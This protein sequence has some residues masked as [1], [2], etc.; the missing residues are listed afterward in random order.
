MTSTLSTLESAFGHQFRNKDLFRQA[1][2][3]PS[4]DLGILD[5]QRLEFLGDAVL[6]LI[7][8]EALY[9]GYPNQP[10][11]RLDQMRASIINGTS[12]AEKAREI[13][14]PNYLEISAA[15]RQ[16]HS[17]PSDGMLEDAFE[18]V[19]GALYLDGG[20]AAAAKSIKR[21]FQRELA[22]A[23]ERQGGSTNPKN[24]LQE[25]VQL[26]YNG[27]KPEYKVLRTAGPAH[28]RSFIV[29]VYIADRPIAC[30][31]GGSK[32]TAETEA[33]EKALLVLKI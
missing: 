14:L 28:R 7:I 16:H 32:K 23:E 20:L 6:G 13:G 4:L 8:A 27:A 29:E 2:R 1:L 22:Q 26:E 17:E 31:Q 5:N 25:W 12:L 19:I 24:R 21:I 15:Q 18:A 3:H 30:G 33:A 10:E 11:G 9:L